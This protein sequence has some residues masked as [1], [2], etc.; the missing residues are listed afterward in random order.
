MAI[1]LGGAA[2]SGA[3][4]AGDGMSNAPN[5]FISKF[6]SFLLVGG[7]VVGKKRKKRKKRFLLYLYFIRRQAKKRYVHVVLLV[8]SPF[9]YICPVTVLYIVVSSYAVAKG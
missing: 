5:K 9:F 1:P 7:K 4:R 2:A 6:I 8:H 3:T